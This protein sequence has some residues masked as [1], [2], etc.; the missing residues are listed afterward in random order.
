[1]INLGGESV[2]QRCLAAFITLYRY[3]PCL[4]STWFTVSPSDMTRQ[5]AYQLASWSYSLPSLLLTEVTLYLMSIFRFQVLCWFLAE[6]FTKLIMTQIEQLAQL[7]KISEAINQGGMPNWVTK[8]ALSPWEFS[9]NRLSRH[10]CSESL[11]KYAITSTT[12]QNSQTSTGIICNTVLDSPSNS[13]QHL[14][15]D[16]KVR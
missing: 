11:L 13:R 7:A 2:L 4:M 6:P 10:Y 16:C 12:K 5:L 1:M 14:S 8:S 9:H 15:L 3:I